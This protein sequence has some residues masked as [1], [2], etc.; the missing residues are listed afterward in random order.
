[1][2]ICVIRRQAIQ[3]VREATYLLLL[4]FSSTSQNFKEVRKIKTTPLERVYFTFKL[5]E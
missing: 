3:F 1:M 5:R 4:S 2:V